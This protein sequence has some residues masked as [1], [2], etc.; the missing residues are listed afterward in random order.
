MNELIR[1]LVERL[2]SSR[3]G[4][5][6]LAVAGVIAALFSLTLYLATTPQAMTVFRAPAFVAPALLIVGAWAATICWR[7]LAPRLRIWCVA[8]A[9]CLAAFGAYAAV[10]SEHVEPL[11]LVVVFDSNVDV[12]A[13]AVNELVSRLRSP[14]FNV[15]VDDRPVNLGLIDR[16]SD[17]DRTKIDEAL[18]ENAIRPSNSVSDRLPVLITAKRLANDQFTNLLSL[19]WPDLVVISTHDVGETASLGDDVVAR[20]VATSVA[21]EVVTANAMRRDTALLP[22]RS[23]GANRGCLSDF[24]RLRETFIQSAQRPALCSDEATG[25]AS[26]FGST[27]VNEL[28]AVFN[29]VAQ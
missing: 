10:R 23:P 2:K 19:T 22:D 13:E 15:L 5:E 11:S 4:S 25:I 8:T 7:Y 14:F 24:H 21:L 3:L 20:Y 16:V 1:L 28:T 12:P 18:E 26:L 29:R 17:S 9:L 27:A 6:F